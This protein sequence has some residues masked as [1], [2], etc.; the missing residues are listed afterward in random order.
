MPG[1]I[2]HLLVPYS[3]YLDH[4]RKDNKRSKY[5]NEENESFI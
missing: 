4:W 1:F 5:V 2:L 3:I